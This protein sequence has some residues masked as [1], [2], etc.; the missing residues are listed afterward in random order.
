MNIYHIKVVLSKKHISIRNVHGGQISLRGH[1]SPILLILEIEVKNLITK[2]A[3]GKS[4]KLFSV[5]QYD[6]K[7]AQNVCFYLW[8]LTGGPLFK[9]FFF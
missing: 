5:F 9:C 7:V 8:K 3:E 4:W 6:I 2:G 1:V